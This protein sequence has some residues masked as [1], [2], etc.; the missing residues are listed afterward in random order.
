MRL[1]LILAA[2]LSLGAALATVSATADASSSNDADAA[3]DDVGAPL[4]M[5]LLKRLYWRLEHSQAA[6]DKRRAFTAM[7]GKRADQADTRSKKM[8]FMAMRG[9][10]AFDDNRYRSFVEALKREALARAPNSYELYDP[11]EPWS[12]NTGGASSAWFDPYFWRPSSS[13]SGSKRAFFAHR[14]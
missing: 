6:T 7:R 8:P 3:D 4:S 2:A 1:V 12:G 14:G 10:K 13:A 9:K 11:Y 5:D